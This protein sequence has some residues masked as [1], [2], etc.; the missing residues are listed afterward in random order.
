MTVKKIEGSNF[1]ESTKD[2][3]IQT[4]DKVVILV[5]STEL[6]VRKE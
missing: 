1:K 3:D 4:E 2:L 5:K 6:T